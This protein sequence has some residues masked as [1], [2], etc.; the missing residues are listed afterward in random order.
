MW[1][2]LRSSDARV[3]AH[4]LGVLTVGI[5]ITMVVPLVTAVVLAEWDP[6]LDYLLGMSLTFVIGVALMLAD[7]R[8][9]GVNRR[10][11]MLVAAL[12]WLLASLVAAIPLSL[13][14]NYASYIDALF[15]AVSGFTTSG[16]TVVI[17]LDHMSHAHNMWRHLTHLIGGQGIVVAA[18]SFAF[19]K[20]G[21]AVSLYTAEGR[22]EKILPN[23]I[24]TTR[25]IWFVTAV[26]VSLGTAALFVFNLWAGM[27]GLRSFLH[28]F[29]ITVAA[30]DT[31]G[32]AP[33]S[34]NALYYHSPI[35]EFLTVMLMLAGTLNFNLHADMWR[36]DPGEIF[37]N[38]ETRT[39]AINLAVLTAFAAV[40]MALAPL[41]N[42]PWQIVRKGAYHVISAH[43]GTGHQTLYAAQWQSTLSAAAFMAVLLAMAAGGAV[44]STAGGIKALRIGLI[45]KS[46]LDGV[47]RSLAPDSAVV[48]TRYHHL[49]DRVLT[50]EVTASAMTLFILYFF[51]YI[52]GGLVGAA[53]G[54][55][56]DV[57]LFE[58]ISATANVGLTA[59][60]TAPTMPLMLK[61]L[62]MLQMWAGRLEFIALFVLVLGVVTSL[63]P[64]RGR[65]A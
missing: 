65:A 1:V 60:I 51:T 10:Q 24:H 2:R 32:F 48:R 59:G 30:Y 36:G 56:A 12:G 16:L 64:R 5:A 20:R 13:S 63:L 17:D 40:G 37:Q 58:S 43:S 6:A 8:P 52:T 21:G 23:V 18:L 33:Q 47:R 19:G 15:D 35:F 38:I 39:L 50:P 53:Y 42:G 57:A 29:W 62:Y 4:Y 34:M 46:I 55:P 25:F 14:G 61:V 7:P 26:F 28:A 27:S 3:V 45:F 22:D 44:S 31:G 11:G 54:Y 49:T 41:L 9:V